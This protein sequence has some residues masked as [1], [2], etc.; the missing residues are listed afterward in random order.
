LKVITLES[1]T[2]PDTKVLN[3]PLTCAEPNCIEDCPNG[4]ATTK[5]IEDSNPCLER[6]EKGLKP[7]CV[8]TCYA[9][10]IDIVPL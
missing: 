8:L 4:V 5:P 3:F 6:L 9:K 2:F 7:A 1:G 10:A